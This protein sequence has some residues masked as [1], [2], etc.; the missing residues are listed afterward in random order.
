ME[1]T[2]VKRN[3]KMLSAGL[4]GVMVITLLAGCGAKGD[5]GKSGSAA[6]DKKEKLI[7]GTSSVSVD[8]A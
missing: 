2:K 1:G 6:E 7:I 3:L 4:C 8:L 5:E